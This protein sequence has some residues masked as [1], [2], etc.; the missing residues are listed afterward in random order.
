MK[1]P[2]LSHRITIQNRTQVADGFGGYTETWA[3]FATVWAEV[4]AVSSRERFFSGKLELNITHKITIRYLAGVEG[5]M[6]ISFDSRIFKIIGARDP[7]ERK[8]WLEI[9]AEEGS[10]N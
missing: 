1:C 2:K 10:G 3:T 9:D 8:A 4:K 6:R 5:D 7:E